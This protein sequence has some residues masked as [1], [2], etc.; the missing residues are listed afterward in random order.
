MENIR[1]KKNISILALF[2]VS[3][4]VAL[5]ACNLF[6]QKQRNVIVIL[7]DTLRADHLSMNGYQRE[8]SPVI[9]N[10]AAENLNFKWALA[11][12]PW[13]PASV[14]SL[15]TGLYPSAHGMVPPNSRDTAIKH[16]VRLPSKWQTMAETFKNNGYYTAA[17]SSNPWIQELFGFTQ[18]FDL[19]GYKERAEAAVLTAKAKEIVQKWRETEKE[20]PLFMYLH[21]LDPHNPYSPPAPYNTKFSGTVEGRVYP[22][23]QQEFI[24]QYDGEILYT[25]TEIGKLFSFLK[26]EGIYDDAVIILLSDHGEQFM[27][28]GHQGHGFDLY[29]EEVHVPLI[30]KANGKK[31]TV[32]DFVSAID[33][34]PTIIELLKLKDPPPFLQ[35][36]SLFNSKELSKRAGVLSEIKRLKNQK[37]LTF[38]D[39]KKAIFE[40]SIDEPYR[41]DLPLPHSKQLMFDIFNDP[42]ESSPLSDPTLAEE[43]KGSFLE[44]YKGVLS[45]KADEKDSQIKMDDKTIKE[46]KTLGYM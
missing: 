43:R 25:D 30:V 42:M 32:S 33:I 9:D 27:E 39:G 24:N 40:F 28:R 21:Y 13:T 17:F 41:M 44:I 1:N 34:F 18:G 46:L 12:A 2:L 36:I 35:G 37:S 5:A 23:K 6:K 26:E 38:K 20:K 11:P 7:I 31:G 14:A 15:F 8:T 19:F 4:S 22:K 45:S 29:N 16:S 10:F 3:I